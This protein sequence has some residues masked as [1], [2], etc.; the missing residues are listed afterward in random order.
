[1]N[2]E[3]ALRQVIREEIKRLDEEMGDAMPDHLEEKARSMGFEPMDRQDLQYTAFSEGALA[4]DMAGGAR[5]VLGLSEG[6][7][8]L[9]L[10]VGDGVNL[11]YPAG[12]AGYVMD[13]L[14]NINAII[15]NKL[16][17]RSEDNVYD[18]PGGRANDIADEINRAY[19]AER[20]V[21]FP[22]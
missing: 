15:K 22:V 20:V 7:P 2:K 5:A 8:I 3:Q 13:N 1:M 17:G 19:N 11:T 18:L 10:E 21:K 14:R 12:D 4:M 16:D 9:W 6:Y